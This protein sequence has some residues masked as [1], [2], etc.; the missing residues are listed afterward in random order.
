MGTSDI[1]SCCSA[2]INRMWN[3]QKVGEKYKRF[4]FTVAK[5]IKHVYQHSKFRSISINKILVVEF[6]TESF[7]ESKKKCQHSETSNLVGL[8]F[9]K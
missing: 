7:T 1:S 9:Q 8:C 2:N 6:M 4:E 5:N 3:V